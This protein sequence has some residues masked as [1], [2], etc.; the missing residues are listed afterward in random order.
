MKM[1]INKR[2]ILGLA[3]TVGLA[4]VVAGCGSTVSPRPQPKATPTA[5]AHVGKATGGLTL[6]QATSPN[7][8][9]EFPLVPCSSLSALGQAWESSG[10]LAGSVV[11]KC[12][13]ADFLSKF[14][15]TKVVAVN[16]DSSLTQAQANAYGQAMV[17]AL[18]WANWAEEDDA[19]SVLTALGQSVGGMAGVYQELVAGTHGVGATP[20]SGAYP[21]RVAILKLT[22]AEATMMAA[23]GA[24]FAIAIGYVQ[25]PYSTLVQYP[26]QS[27]KTVTAPAMTPAIYTGSIAT[28]PLLGTYF[29]VTSLATDCSTGA[30]AGLCTIAGVIG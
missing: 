25:E 27:P 6:A 3:G 11:G 2:G 8:N 4:I 14:V 19:P 26:G 21:N 28:S 24:T 9:V 13:P 15:P 1:H 12:P 10:L 18:G 29:K 17:N 30:A 23:P 16:L 5:K 7:F 22:P 20:G